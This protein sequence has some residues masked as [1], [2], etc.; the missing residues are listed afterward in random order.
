VA[1]CT[2]E[3]KESIVNLT[4]IGA[5]F[6]FGGKLIDRLIPDPAQKLQAQQE[7]MKMAMDKELA[8]MANETKVIELAKDTITTEGGSDDKWTSRAR[9][10]FMYV[11]YVLIL[12]AIPMGVLYAFTPTMAANVITGFKL[13]LSAI[14]ADMLALFAVGYTGYV[15]ARTFEKVKNAGK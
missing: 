12:S 10:T 8:V 3:E 11:I 4:G 2:K 7:L 13:W 9:P 1:H 15:G 6:D 5:I 14:P